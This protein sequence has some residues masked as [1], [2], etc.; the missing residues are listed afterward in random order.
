MAASSRKRTFTGQIAM[1]LQFGALVDAG[2]GRLVVMPDLDDVAIGVAEIF[3][4]FSQ[5]LG[6]ERM[7]SA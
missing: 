3:G 7:L 4:A 5:A 1:G 6:T 2:L